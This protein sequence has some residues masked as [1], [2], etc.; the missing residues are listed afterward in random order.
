MMATLHTQGISL[1]YEVYGEPSNP[2]VLL[3]SGLGGGGKS[4]GPQIERFAES[5]YL[6]LPDQRGTGQSSRAEDGYTTQQLAA[7]MASLV[8]HLANGPVHLVGSSTGG[9][10]AQYVALNHPHTVRSLTISSS[11]ARFDAFTRREFEVRRRMAA[12]WD[13]PT[14]L[15]GYSL[16]L[17]SPRYTREY[18]ERI[19]AWIQ[20]AAAHPAQPDDHEIAMKRI[21]MIMAHNALARLGEITQPTLVLC[22]EHNFCTPLPLSEEIAHAVPGAEFIIFEDAGEL[23]ELEKEEE[24]FQVVSSFIARHQLSETASPAFRP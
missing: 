15:A 10:I 18:P 16:F 21:D 14:L 17:F 24:F 19:E 2:P 9:A 3:V 11:F 22:G 8:E 13:R 23:I 5:H 7:D 20:R 4:W 1:Y 12:E 6:I